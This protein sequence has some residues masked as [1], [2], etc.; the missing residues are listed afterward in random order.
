MKHLYLL[1]LTFFIGNS[2][3][4]SEFP[5][6]LEFCRH[7]GISINTSVALDNGDIMLFARVNEYSPTKYPA[8]ITDPIVQQQ[9]S[10]Q[11]G[12]FSITINQNF[13]IQAI[14]PILI[15]TGS[16]FNPVKSPTAI[17]FLLQSQI[18]SINAIYI[19]KID[20]LGNLQYLTQSEELISQ[21][22]FYNNKLYAVTQQQIEFALGSLT[23]AG[24]LH[25]L[26]ESTGLGQ[27]YVIGDPDA[28]II[29]YLGLAVNETGI[30]VFSNNTYFPTFPLETQGFYY[31]PGA[32][33]PYSQPTLYGGKVGALTKYDLTTATRTWSTYLGGT[34]SLHID[35]GKRPNNLK[36][37]KGDIY[38]LGNAINATNIATEGVF[39]TIE[40]NSW[41]MMRFN[42]AGERLMGT[43][44]TPPSVAFPSLSQRLMFSD[45]NSNSLNIIG[46][47]N[48][49]SLASA[50]SPQ[51]HLVGAGDAFLSSFS[52]TGQRLYAT[53][54][55]AASEDLPLSVHWF[56]DNIIG[57]LRTIAVYNSPLFYPTTDSTILLPLALAENDPS[58]NT[59]AF[60]YSNALNSASFSQNIAQLYPNPTNGLLNIVYENDIANIDVYTIDGKK[61]K[62][63]I[64]YGLQQAQ[65]DASA[66]ANGIYIL[67]LTDKDNKVQKQKFVKE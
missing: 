64:Q 10:G 40:T 23:S 20:L 18:S 50:N 51:E 41:F 26:E 17:Y 48:T 16:L 46:S 13:E 60:K 12:Y 11:S 24:K 35:D 31:T 7:L 58:L 39:S 22:T 37:F 6:D 55:G 42:P 4:Q 32:F 52:D 47:A 21:L 36:I 63:A 27:S 67:V 1:L 19:G 14:H 49:D 34:G 53:Y 33:Q 9:W 66:L 30:Y 54:L 57:F 45:D 8:F 15:A 25:I 61:I 5:Y 59:L 56:E 29:G 44:L 62:V 43:F 3:A 2:F 65:L 28:S 38:A